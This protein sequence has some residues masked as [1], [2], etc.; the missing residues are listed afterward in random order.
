MILGNFSLF[1]ALAMIIFDN[2]S[3]VSNKIL[4]EVKLGANGYKAME[5]DKIMVCTRTLEH[6]WTGHVLRKCRERCAKARS[7]TEVWDS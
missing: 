6:I 3:G 7:V 1:K 4:N 2:K 5:W